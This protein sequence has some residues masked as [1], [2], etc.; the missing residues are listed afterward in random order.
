MISEQLQYIYG[1]PTRPENKAYAY[2]PLTHH[3]TKITEILV[4]KAYLI[5]I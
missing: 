3:K 4:Q 1:W 5:K 2:I